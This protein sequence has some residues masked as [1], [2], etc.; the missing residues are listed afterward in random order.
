M[1]NNKIYG[2]LF[3]AKLSISFHIRTIIDIQFSRNKNLLQNKLIHNELQILCVWIY[4]DRRDSS[5]IT[6]D[7]I[8]R[9]WR[10][11]AISRALRMESSGPQ[12]STELGNKFHKFMAIPYESAELCN[13]ASE[14]STNAGTICGD[15]CEFQERHDREIC[16][17]VDDELRER[18]VTFALAIFRF[19]SRRNEPQFKSSE[20]LPRLLAISIVT[21]FN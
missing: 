12:W 1:I 7:E 16:R 21:E 5:R 9:K 11:G 10:R 20:F 13:C 15:F 18:R 6:R 17:S 2:F 4:V 8:E 14:I 3:V 19:V